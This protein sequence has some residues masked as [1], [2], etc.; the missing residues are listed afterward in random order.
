MKPFKEKQKKHKDKI[1]HSVIEE[2]LGW[3]V[4]GI[5]GLLWRLVVGFFQL[6]GRAIAGLFHHFF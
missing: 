2:I 4:E 5:L 3:I 1:G 6:L